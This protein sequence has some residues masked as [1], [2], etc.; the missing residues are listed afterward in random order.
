M[1]VEKYDIA[2]PLRTQA[3]LNQY[4]VHAKKSLGQNFLQEPTVIDQI[5]ASAQIK[6]EDVVLEIGPGIGALTQQLAKVAQHVYAFELDADLITLLQENL[7]DYHNLTVIQADFLQVDLAQFVQTEHLT[8]TN[9][10][11]V[12]NLPYYITTPILWKLLQAPVNLQRLVLMMQKEVAQRIT[13]TPGHREFGELSVNVQ[14][15]AT[16]KIEQLVDKKAFVPQPKVD[17]AVVSL[18]LAQRPDYQIVDE[19]WFE[20]VVKAAFQQKRKNL[21]NNLLVLVGKSPVNKQKLET[22]FTNLNWQHQ[23][24]AEQ[25]TIDQLEQ[26]TQQVKQQFA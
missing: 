8:Q 4:Q 18:D 22:V 16:V 15:K 2:D 21:W 3:I 10:K 23:V 24:R 12:A 9:L 26:L 19:V 6:S 7:A 13:A 20:R 5:V 1:V 11:V 14:T 25:L 17:S